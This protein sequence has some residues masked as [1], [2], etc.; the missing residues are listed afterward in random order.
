LISKGVALGTLS[1]GS[2]Q[3][4]NYPEDEVDLLNAVAGQFSIAVENARL[5]E[6]ERAAA[7][8]LRVSERNYRDIF[9]SASDPI[10]THSLDSKILAFNQALCQLTGYE[11]KALTGS[12][13]SR[14]F[15]DHGL[16]PASKETHS[17]VLRGETAPTYEHRLVK[18]DG[19][20][21]ILQIGTSLIT[22]A[23]EPWAF[24]HIARDI[25]AE[26]RVQDNLRLY[27]Q[28][29]SQAQEAE[30]KRIARELHDETAQ[31]LVVISRH[32]GDLAAGRPEFTAK[33]IREEVRKVL[34]GVRN[35][36]QELRP[37]IL[38]DLG[39]LSALKWLAADLTKKYGIVAET[40]IDGEPH[41]LS[42]ES[43]LTLFRIT[44]EALN[45]IRR[46]SQATE[47]SVR[48][49][50][51]EHRIRLTI[52]DNGQGFSLPSE[53]GDLTR[54]G[55]LGLA[56]MQERAQLLGG[57]LTVESQIGKGTTLIIEAPT[58]DSKLPG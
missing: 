27:T 11:A 46:H 44:Q 2:S 28:K 48:I 32:L 36:S 54:I 43:E 56:G 39:L 31:E 14:L 20:E 4:H 34:E 30:R 17:R 29:V 9:E 3:P 21:V 52:E 57:T 41:Q 45:N 13:V 16:T 15:P 37:S 24:Q 8:A 25:T 6:K 1:V 42:P 26:R 55:K 22:R 51:S 23:G 35:F 19:S 33:N 50:F 38:D 53:V 18:K 49:E 10:W 5:Y 40:S 12:D 58:M 7:E 47:A